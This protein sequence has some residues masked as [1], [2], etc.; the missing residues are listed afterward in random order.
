MSLK[1]IKTLEDELNDNEQLY[2]FLKLALCTGGRIST[3]A[4][5][6]KKDVNIDNQVISLTDFKSCSNYKGFI[7]DSIIELLSSRLDDIEP[8]DEVL[9]YDNSK[10]LL[11][12]L[13]KRMRPILNKLF[14][15]DLA[16]DDRLILCKFD[17][18]HQILILLFPM[19]QNL[20]LLMENELLL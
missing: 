13:G 2:L 19:V 20:M 6:K 8:D 17:Y 18:S 7:P 16:L 10:N 5:I 14:N 9:N 15:Q 4:N 11:A 3:I 12:Q 1:E